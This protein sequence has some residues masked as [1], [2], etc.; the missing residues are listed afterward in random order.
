MAKDQ[1]LPKEEKKKEVKANDKELSTNKEVKRDQE[2]QD[3]IEVKEKTIEVV[4]E[5]LVST[6]E[7]EFSKLGFEE[8]AKPA[9]EYG[10]GKKYGFGAQ[11][12]KFSVNIE[13]VTKATLTK[14]T[15]FGTKRIESQINFDYKE[16]TVEIEYKTTEAGSFR[17]VGED[18]IPYA[19]SKS[20]TIKNS[21]IKESNKELKDF[22]KYA[23]NK[24]VAYLINTKLG[25]DDKLSKGTTS[26][27]NESKMEKLTIKSLFAD[28]FKVI[29]EGKK[30]KDVK[31]GAN[32]IPMSKVKHH[33]KE[34]KNKDMFFD[35]E[36]KKE[37][38]TIAERDVELKEVTMSGPAIGG[39][40]GGFKDGAFSG[41]G[42]YNTPNFAKK[43]N[44]ESTNYAKNKRNK[45]PKIDE[46][47]N[48]ISESRENDFNPLKDT[49][50]N[51]DG[52]WQVVK[53]DPETH[54]LGLPFVKPNSKE[55]LKINSKGMDKDKARRM[56]LEESENTKHK[57]DLTKKKIF[58]EE[59]NKLK[60]INKRYLIT[61]KTSDEY[62]KERWEKLSIFKLNESIKEAEELSSVY[63]ELENENNDLTYNHL[64]K[65]N[66][67]NS[68]EDL[69][70]LENLNLNEGE[71]T[72]EVEKPNSMFG[73]EYSFYKKDF[74]NESKKYILDLNSRVFVPNPN[75]K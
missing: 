59:E 58:S 67:E 5:L 12:N 56:G 38:K 53:V 71:E 57:L 29:N 73:I 64:E 45:R 72:I 8:V 44:F 10:T 15:T 50:G 9:G 21:E 22:F 75:A 4:K 11:E 54:P 70:N 42:G 48:V 33:S 37:K 62:L 23:A 20:I 18:K 61:E 43:Q 14:K 55:E 25:V 27:V 28:D 51:N 68:N 52:F 34:N 1:E 19:F 69:N 41:A 74:L 40:A 31:K 47:Y 26:T 24:E 60:G 65:L 36:S 39:S 17:G 35:E 13:G 2:H 66:D 6:T 16:T 49:K 7:N 30:E 63:E 32:T 3:K 46:N